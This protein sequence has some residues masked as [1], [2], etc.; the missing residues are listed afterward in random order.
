MQKL[1]LWFCAILCS[2]CVA[3]NPVPTEDAAKTPLNVCYSS[4]SATQAVA[5]YAVEKGIYATYGLDVNLVYIESGSKATAALIAGEMDLCQIAGSAVVNGAVAGTDLVLIAGLIN[6]HAYSL[7]V[8]PAIQHGRDLQGK[9]LAVSDFGGS[10]DTATRAALQSLN[11]RPDEDVAILAIGGQSERLAAMES[12]AVVG[13]VVSVPQTAQARALGYHELVN[14]AELKTPF[15][16]TALATSRALI[17]SDRA[18]VIRFLEATI[19]A[20]AQMKADKAGVIDVLSHYLLLDKHAHEAELAEAHAVLIQGYLPDMPYPTEE[21]V[22][23]LLDA[24]A[25]ENP[26]AADYTAADVIDRTLLDEIEASGF[27]ETLN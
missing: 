1:A 23:V 19:D 18:T 26:A 16:H 12:G 8:T 4:A 2:G 27:R 25:A 17:A 5:M 22:Q 15:Q 14:M 13:T 11:L 21:G 3:I 20:I 7:M 24:L 10:S 9:A 6:T